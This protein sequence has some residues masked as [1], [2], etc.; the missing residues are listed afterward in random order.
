MSPEQARGQPADQR[1]DVYSL[2]VMLYEMLSG[3]PLFSGASNVD[4]LLAQL[5]QIP[6]PLAEIR[7]ELAQVPELDAVVMRCLAKKPDDRF[8]GMSELLNTLKNVFGRDPLTSGPLDTSPQPAPSVPPSAPSAVTPVRLVAQGAPTVAL[9]TPPPSSAR[10]PGMST[11]ARRRLAATPP[12]T[13][14]DL[15]VSGRRRPVVLLGAAAGGAA[16]V[17]IAIWAL[18]LIKRPAPALPPM[19]GAVAAEIPPAASPESRDTSGL[20]RSP[21]PLGDGSLS[22]AAD[23]HAPPA[24]KPHPAATNRVL[25]HLRS[26][27]SGAAVLVGKELICAATPCEVHWPAANG[28]QQ[29]LAFRFRL[30]GYAEAVQLEVLVSPEMTVSAGLERLRTRSMTRS[31]P[32]SEPRSPKSSPKSEPRSRD[33]YKENPY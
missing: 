33:D 19:P 11:T 4:V 21:P 23:A 24:E 12:P 25:I 29:P 18:L 20:Q 30:T 17:A 28:L 16:V 5:Q 8:A 3:K 2:G 6:A 15:R 22:P 31:R 26:T 1:S 10:V 13:P 7:P 9:P 14:A 27:P 32:K